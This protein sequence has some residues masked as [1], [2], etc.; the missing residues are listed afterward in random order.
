[1]ARFITADE[2]AGLIPDGAAIAV[3]AFTAVS[4][5]E[6]IIVAVSDRFEK[7]GHPRDLSLF[8]ISGVGD[9][10]HRGLSHFNR[11][12]LVRKLTGSHIFAEPDLIPLIAENKI[13]TYCLP[14]GAASHLVRA[15]AG[16]EDGLLTKCGLHTFA[17][18][19]QD[20]CK[21]N[22]ACKEDVVSLVTID[23]REHLFFKAPRFD[24]CFLKGSLADGN[25][26]ISLE[27]EPV[28]L[29]QLEMAA[30]TKA[31]G[32][33]VIVQVHE[34]VKGRL[35]PR[36][37][38]IPAHFVDYVVVGRKENTFQ[39]HIFPEYRPELTGETVIDLK[40]L[41]P[42]PLDVRKVCG[43]RGVMEIR[44]NALVNIGGGYPEAVATV[45][46]EEGIS[47]K[48]LFSVE[49]GLIGGVPVEG[50]IGLSYNPVAVLRQP[51]KF[52]LYNGGALDICFLGCGE[53]DAQGNV[54]VSKF[55]GRVVGPGGFVNISQNTKNV[56]FLG[57]FTAGKSDI[58]IVDKKLRIG[59]DGTGKK[60]VKKVEQ[61]TFSGA[62]ALKNG[63]NALYITERC[64]FQ[65][66]PTGV[67]LIEIAPG[68]DLQ[69]DILDR[70][71]FRPVI[72]PDLKE[73][74]PRIFR[75]Q[76]M[77]LKL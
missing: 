61:I 14:Q 1:M 53:V 60:Y 26:N 23:G 3:S 67:T 74:D 31:C 4:L 75:D 7:D 9:Y 18:P 25:G 41:P 35:N 10:K 27:R 29:E 42:K 52:D 66:R 13:E 33:K 34:V 50:G 57:S 28:L 11:E 70:M 44:K 17:D 22:K 19:R 54:N 43:R 72:A 76:K 51:E 12:G 49:S 48:F 55:A 40:K 38:K 24:F 68:V 15:M 20:G 45:A 30:A 62:D 71:D 58:S 32:G 64:V 56:C 65:L 73:M 2:A 21:M 8:H 47:D 5:A 77:G 36:N 63:Q 37:I 59:A 39:T 16:G 69:K 46:A 6:D